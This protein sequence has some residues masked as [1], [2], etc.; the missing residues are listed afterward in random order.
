MAEAWVAETCRMQ[1]DLKTQMIARYDGRTV[2][3]EIAPERKDALLNG[4]DDIAV[5]LR[6]SGEISRWEA[7]SER[8]APPIPSN[9]ASL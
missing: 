5:S 7:Q 8:I 3:F 2:A 9:V 1:V 6:K 4:V